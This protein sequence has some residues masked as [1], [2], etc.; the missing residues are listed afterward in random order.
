MTNEF[1]NIVPI[2]RDGEI[3][4]SAEITVDE[5][6]MH[7]DM[8]FHNPKHKEIQETIEYVRRVMT[9]ILYEEERD[10]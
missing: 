3:I 2:T 7:I 4:G 9:N 5:A 10:A 6:G 1:S 8:N